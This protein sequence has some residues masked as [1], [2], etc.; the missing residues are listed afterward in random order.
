MLKRKFVGAA[1]FLAAGP[2]LL[3]AQTWDPNNPTMPSLNINIGSILT[4]LI[5]YLAPIIG[6]TTMAGLAFYA[7]RKGFRWVRGA[8]R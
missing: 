5:T 8:F 6:V 3:L 1:L 2:A 4:S 7:I